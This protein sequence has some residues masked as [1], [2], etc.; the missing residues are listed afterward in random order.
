M[1]PPLAPYAPVSP[2]RYALLSGV[3]VAALALGGALA[4]LLH[5]LAPVVG[6]AATLESLTDLPLLG[7]VSTA[8]PAEQ[9]RE[10]GRELKH[11]I[12]VASGLVGL[13]AVVLLLNLAHM[14][15]SLPLKL[16]G[17]G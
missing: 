9:R 2:L 10:A 12:T 8:F 13:F 14:R 3:M 7:V 15:L 11:F 4:Y 16:L 5:L 1:Q 6:S 17:I